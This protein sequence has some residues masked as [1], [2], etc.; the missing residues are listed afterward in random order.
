MPIK[1]KVVKK[2]HKEVSHIYAHDWD[3]L[4]GERIPRWPSKEEPRRI[5]VLI[6]SWSGISPGASHYHV[7][8]EIEQQQWWCENENA[9]I[10]LSC[11]MTGAPYNLRA[12]LPRKGDAE[13]VADH[14]I[15]IIQLDK[16]QLW[17]IDR[18][19]LDED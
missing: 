1:R 11:D 15:S 17:K 6:N 3:I 2:K 7:T 13:I 9:W 10:S 19:G 16:S 14:F 18:S 5:K 8:V 4:D 12:S